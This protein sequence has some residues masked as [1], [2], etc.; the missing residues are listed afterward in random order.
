MSDA[1]P[2]RDY[3]ANQQKIIKRY[4]DNLD[5]ISL[6]RLAEL[7]GEL[8]LAEGKKKEKAWQAAIKVMHTLE[9]PQS[10][11]DNLAQRQDPTLVAELVKEL[12]TKK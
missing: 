4:Y 6:D 10:R 11:I 5:T 7:V 8:Y 2:K 1:K 12:Q 9:V 3:T